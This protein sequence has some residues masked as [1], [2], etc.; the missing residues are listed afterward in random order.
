MSVL[1]LG[2]TGERGNLSRHRAGVKPCPMS[3]YQSHRIGGDLRMQ[4]ILMVVAF[5]LV[6]LGVFV[7][8]ASLVR[9]MNLNIDG[10]FIFIWV[11]LAASLVNGAFGVIYADIPIINEVAAFIPIFGIPAAAAWYVSRRMTSA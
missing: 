8:I 7:A 11:W 4:H 1:S 10:A 9:R 2:R 5:G 3:C 6:A